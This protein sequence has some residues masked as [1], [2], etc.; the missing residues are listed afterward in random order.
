M[1][2][3]KHIEKRLDQIVRILALN[4]TKDDKKDK[5]KVLKL[6]KMGFNTKEIA[7]ILGIGANEIVKIHLVDVLDNEKKKKAYMLTGTKTQSEIREMLKMSPNDISELW[8]ECER[9]GLMS[10]KGKR[11]KPL[12]DL[13][14]FKLVPRDSKARQEAEKVNAQAEERKTE[15]N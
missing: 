12:F 8:Q 5:D 15:N 1:T 6:T 3:E 13:R 9:R 7:E 2:D 11:Y 14:K 10:K 4:V